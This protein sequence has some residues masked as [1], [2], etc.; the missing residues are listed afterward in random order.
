[1]SVETTSITPERPS[2]GPDALHPASPL[3]K[4]D[5]P[6]TKGP[7][8]DGVSTTE[9]RHTPRR[10]RPPAEKP[11]SMDVRHKPARKSSHEKYRPKSRSFEAGHRLKQQPNQPPKEITKDM[12]PPSEDRESTPI[13]TKSDRPNSIGKPEGLILGP[14]SPLEVATKETGSHKPEESRTP[15]AEGHVAPQADEAKGEKKPP[16]KPKRPSVAKRELRTQAYDT[17]APEMLQPKKI[18]GIAEEPVIEPLIQATESVSEKV[19]NLPTGWKVGE[20]SV[21]LPDGRRIVKNIVTG[22]TMIVQTKDSEGKKLPVKQMRVVSAGEGESTANFLAR[23]IPGITK[24][25]MGL[26]EA[27]TSKP[28]STAKQ[29][30][31]LI[32][33]SFKHESL[34][35]EVQENEKQLKGLESATTAEVQKNEAKLDYLQRRYGIESE[36]E[37]VDRLQDRRIIKSDEKGTLTRERNEI[38]RYLESLESEG[39]DLPAEYLAR[40]QDLNLVLDN[41]KDFRPGIEGKGKKWWNIPVL[42]TEKLL[43]PGPVEPAPVEPAPVEG[44]LIDATSTLYALDA[45]ETDLAKARRLADDQINKEMREISEALFQ[46]RNPAD[47]R[48]FKMAQTIARGVRSTFRHPIQS[49]R[50]VARST[51]LR[52]GYRQ[53]YIHEHFGSMEGPNFHN[54]VAEAVAERF[55]LGKDYL[56]SGERI[57]AE[58]RPE[59]RATKDRL[60]QIFNQ[61]INGIM[62]RATVLTEAQRALAEAT[63]IGNGS[64]QHV[65]MVQNLEQ[66]YDRITTS[67]EH[68]AGLA[69][70][71]AAYRLVGGETELGVNAEARRTATDRIME[72]LTNSR[73]KGYLVNEATV[74]V[75]VGAVVSIA[76][77]L[78]RSKGARLAS[79]ML[80][81][82][83]V[84]I[85]AAAG[86]AALFS[87]ARERMTL[88]QERALRMSQIASG[89]EGRANDPDHAPRSTEIDA[90]IYDMA[91]SADIL[92]TY[93]AARLVDITNPTEDEAN[94][95]LT[96]LVALRA[97]QTVGDEKSID[98]IRYTSEDLIETEKT[99]IMTAR[100][101]AERSLSRFAT[102]HPD[103]LSG[104]PGVSLEDKLSN[105]VQR[106]I[107]DNIAETVSDRDRAFRNLSNSRAS[108]RALATFAFA[109][110]GSYISA[111]ISEHFSG[112]RAAQTVTN[113]TTASHEVTLPNQNI[114]YGLRGDS[115]NMPEGWRLDG[116]A[117]IDSQGNKL[118]ENI[119]FQPDGGIPQDVLDQL[120]GR[121]IGVSEAVQNHTTTVTREV[122]FGDYMALHPEKFHTVHR[123][124][125]MGNNTPMYRDALGQ[126]RGADLNELGGSFALDP[127]TGNIILGTNRMTDAGSFWGAVRVAAHT[128]QVDGKLRWLFAPD[129]S[130]QSQAF[131][132]EVEP[133][134][135]VVIPKGSELYSLFNVDPNASGMGQV[136]LRTGYAEVAVPT[137]RST[138][139]A[140]NFMVLATQEGNQP[141]GPVVINENVDFSTT[142]T[143]LVVTKTIEEIVE[144][145]ETI[146]GADW[147]APF[148]PIAAPLPR[149]PLER[150]M[151]ATPDISIDYLPDLDGRAY[152]VDEKTRKRLEGSMSSRLLENPD[153]VLDSFEEVKGYIGRLTVEK[154]ILVESL[155]DQIEQPMSMN[156][157]VA[158]V[159][160][161]AGAQEG[162]NIY[163]ALKWYTGQKDKSGN[164][165]DNNRFEIVLY[166]NKTSNLDWDDTLD[167]IERF[168]RDY[169]DLPVRVATHSYDSDTVNFGELHKDLVDLTLERQRRR[170]RVAADL[171]VVTNDADTK[172]IGEEYLDTILTQMDAQGVDAIAGRLEWDP[173][174]YLQ[175]PLFMAAQQFSERINLISRHPEPGSTQRVVY[176]GS[177]ANFA[178]KSSIYAA[179]G[180]EWTDVNVGPDV[181]LRDSIYFARTRAGGTRRPVG[182]AG[183][184]DV[185]YSS[186]RRGVYA[187]NLGFAPSEQWDESKVEFSAADEL[188]AQESPPTLRDT[189][190][191]DI[192]FGPDSYEKT[193]EIRRFVSE[194]EYFLE[195][196][197]ASYGFA[198]P[199][200]AS[201]Y[202][203][204]GTIPQDARLLSRAL[205]AMYLRPGD[206][207]VER[208]A[209]ELKIKII[210]PDRLLRY[211]SN[212]KSNGLRNYTA[213]T[214]LNGIFA[215]G[216]PEVFPDLASAA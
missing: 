23:E 164:A 94:R 51:F 41:A 69:S 186:S 157:E 172:G 213:R 198:N 176:Q 192:L 143:T 111:Q 109:S 190:D 184:D 133:G 85:V 54:A 102:T 7:R 100:A 185:V 206:V 114:P 16:V 14:T 49:F 170:G 142:E 181:V 122:P 57:L 70:I 197:A 155:A 96:W 118:V 43:V 183:G 38:Q 210:N 145:R 159:I 42:A 153:A 9:S 120:R 154:R 6:D 119:Q 60:N 202:P 40:L 188:R 35:S 173:Y 104:V 99:Q 199:D 194:L 59:V 2:K 73:M 84:G 37:F 103:F 74:A 158:V 129:K 25:G 195:R 28:V 91:S 180:G 144:T 67:I 200:R 88:R 207:E 126:L 148:I 62:D 193:N 112:E 175:S 150:I 97:N 32:E 156:C 174:N 215:G 47:N 105:M 162:K 125:W 160:P 30:A 121:G 72:R 208:R 149:R 117:I 39:K 36:E 29:K 11:R 107:Q 209:G 18:D 77:Y 130:H 55:D 27:E 79:G 134:G 187:F 20:G 124:M 93:E 76:G 15:G 58:D 168:K 203:G 44:Q 45:R 3:I 178:F 161:V 131:V 182:F 22:E 31:Q 46:P 140:E 165:L 64:D 53:H 211:L 24:E 12:V 214:N 26:V 90:T 87:A 167:E 135:T 33:K 177:G 216:P 21:E 5:I 171:V 108:K 19:E 50:Y 204:S 89:E 106:S 80:L 191:Y 152:E 132:L 128:E 63:W 66:I 139:G 83:P 141:P 75:A 52:E 205:E 212:Y 179:V 61:G 113:E 137:G 169:P 196:T 115:I 34:K 146:P 151:P 86:S 4:E 78:A 189:I 95:L 48:F 138:G 147:R 201:F 71:D 123:E 92:G 116:N 56:Q 10:G 110:V 1:M 166:V 17:K 136:T 101:E 163:N 68:E 82:G 81:G 65:H 127:A 98:L 13:T 8:V